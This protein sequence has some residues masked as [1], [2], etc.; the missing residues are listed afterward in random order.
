MRPLGDPY[1]GAIRQ[2]HPDRNLQPLS[3]RVND[4]NHP[5]SPLRPAEDLQGDTMERMKRVEDLHLRSFRTQGI[6][7]V[8]ALIPMFIASL[9]PADSP[10]A[11]R[12]GCIRNTLSSCPSKCSAGFSAASS[13]TASSELI[14]RGRFAFPGPTPHCR[15]RNTFAGFYAPC[16][17][18]TGSSMP[19]RPL[20]AP[21]RCCATSADTPT[22]SPSAIIAYWLSM[23]SESRSAGR[24]TRTATNN[25]R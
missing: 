19:N 11:G 14:V 18:K 13:R 15:S 8:G 9:R 17:A 6:V 12:A 21:P 16:S 4:R 3:R 5:I 1:L 10:R 25:G 22:V 7:G 20:A 23:A 24:T 2:Q